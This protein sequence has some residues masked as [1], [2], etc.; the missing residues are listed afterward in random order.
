LTLEKN[1]SVVILEHLDVGRNHAVGVDTR[2]EHVG[3][4]VVDAVLYFVLED[5]FNLAVLGVGLYD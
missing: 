4:R 2:A 1:L 5:G 3:G